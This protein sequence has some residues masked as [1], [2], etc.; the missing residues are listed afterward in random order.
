MGKTCTTCLVEKEEKE[1]YFKNKAKCKYHA[2]CKK[3]KHELDK[4]VYRNN[5]LR[6]S[7]L[8]KAATEKA[9]FIREYLRRVRKLFNCQKCGDNRHYV[10]DFHHRSDKKFNLAR[11][12]SSGYSISNIKKEI[13]K[14]DVLCSNCHREL[15]YFES[16]KEV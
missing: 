16:I 7:T 13:K 14:C 12:A 1:F 3:C 6:R 9:L 15:H 2:V 11:A 4:R 5:P 8:R 10:L